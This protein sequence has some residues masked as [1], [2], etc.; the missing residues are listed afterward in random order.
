MGTSH[1]TASSKPEGDATLSPRLLLQAKPEEGLGK[2]QLGTVILYS[3][4]VFH[5][6]WND[7]PKFRDLKQHPHG[8][9]A[10]QSRWAAGLCFE[11]HKAKVGLWAARAGVRGRTPFS[12]RPCLGRSQLPLGG[13]TEVLTFCWL[14][15]RSQWSSFAGGLFLLMWPPPS[16]SSK[17]R[18]PIRFFLCLDLSDIR[19]APA[20]ADSPL[21]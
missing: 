21:H 9:I 8:L 13:K 18:Q 3:L 15:A 10:Q 17:H 11:T 12:A 14:L 6:C 7:L 20:R 1:S 5:C 4:L 2:G 16:P 19:P